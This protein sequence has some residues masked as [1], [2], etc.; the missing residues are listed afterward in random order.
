MGEVI[1]RL[2]HIPV[3]GVTVLDENG[4]YNVYIND[5]LTFEQRRKVVDHEMNH[6]ELEHFFDD[7]SVKDLEEEASQ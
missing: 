6:I 1:I 3:P 4:D 7:R 5:R 2:A